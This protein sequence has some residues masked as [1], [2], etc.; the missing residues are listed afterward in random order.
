MSLQHICPSFYSPPPPTS[1]VILSLV[2]LLQ[3]SLSRWECVTFTTY[4]KSSNPSNACTQN[5][6]WHLSPHS[7]KRNGLLGSFQ[8][9]LGQDL[10]FS[11]FDSNQAK[12]SWHSW[13]FNSIKIWL[14]YVR[15]FFWHNALLRQE[16]KS[17]YLGFFLSSLSGA[18]CG[19]YPCSFPVN[20]FESGWFA[21]KVPCNCSLWLTLF[22]II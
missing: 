7:V 14:K 10:W 18:M 21:L 11:Y 3:Q 12:N 13:S 19:I 8:S 9:Q 22:W 2:F 16:R 15:L 17:M 5:T 4:F 1:L 20:L 6:L